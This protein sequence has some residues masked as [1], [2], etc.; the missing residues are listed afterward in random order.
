MV[1]GQ[2]ENKCKYCND[3]GKFKRRFNM[4]LCDRHYRQLLKYGEVIQTSRDP[5]NY[6][7]VITTNKH[8]VKIDEEDVDRCKKYKWRSCGDNGYIFT[9][10][11]NKKVYLQNYILNSCHTIDHINHNIYDCRKDNLREADKSKNMMNSLLSE[12]N[13]SG[14]KGVCYDKSRE[15][16]LATIKKDG[17]RYNLGRYKN[18]NDAVIVRFKKEVELFG[19]YSIYHNKNDKTYSLNY[20]YNNQKYIITYN[21]GSV[22]VDVLGNEDR[23][24]IG[25]TGTK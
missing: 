9:T 8:D 22:E 10:I 2:Q 6:Y 13:T 5:N 24:G 7:A 19:E 21:N 12:I 14:V 15:K 4:I 17:L 25:S 1:L 23:G 18:F 16:W 11:N 20:D 3:N